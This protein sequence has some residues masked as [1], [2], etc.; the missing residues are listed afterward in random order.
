MRSIVNVRG[1]VDRIK[2]ENHVRSF[3]SLSNDYK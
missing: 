3:I 1:H 2:T